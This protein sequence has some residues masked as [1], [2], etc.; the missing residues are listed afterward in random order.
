MKVMKWIILMCMTFSCS[1]FL[2]EI[3]IKKREK[4]KNL[5][6]QQI[7]NMTVEEKIAQMFIIS[8]RKGEMDAKLEELLNLQPG[9]FIL[10][11]E[12]FTTYEKTIELIER[13]E[14]TAKISMFLSIDQEGGRVQRLKNL[15]DI[16]ATE[17]PSML[18][19]GKTSDESL[20]EKVGKVLAEELRVFGINMDFAP[21]IDIVTDEKNQ[22]IG[23]R[24]FGTDYNTVSKMGLAVA[25]GLE[26]NGVIPVYKHFPGH[27]ST[28]T[29]SHYYLP[30][31]P[32]TKEELFETDLIPFQQAIQNQAEIIMVGHLAVPSI[33]KNEIP[34]TLSR[35]LVTDLLKNEMG[36]QGLVVSDALNMGALTKHYTEKE[37]YE[38]AIDAGVDLLLMPIDFKRAISYVKESIDEGKISL[39]QIHTSLEKILTLKAKK[40]NNVKLEREYLGSDLHKT[41]IEKIKLSQTR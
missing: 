41:I 22:V 16:Y 7:D 36:Y 6:Q 17:I 11:Q 25:K 27:G 38:Q 4:I 21:V 29:D 23:N 13:I 8:Y 1:R 15:E 12:N 37:I 28:I 5:V 31:I 18:E 40:L 9:G 26:N 24:S 2:P 19:L 35:T 33:T 34:A 30:V 14:K 10:F 32:K 3:E 20:G 39:E